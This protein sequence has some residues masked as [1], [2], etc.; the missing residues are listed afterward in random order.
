[1]SLRTSRARRLEALP[2]IV[3]E[4]IVRAA[5]AED[6]GLGGDI[7]S[8]ATVPSGTRATA[9]LVARREGVLAGLDPALLAFR[10]LDPGVR[11]EVLARDGED[12]AQNQTIATLSGD[13]RALLGAERT[14]LNLL[15]HMSGIATATAAYVA[16]VGDERC[17]ICETRKTLPGL[18]AL[19]KYAVRAGGGANH[20]FRLDDAVLIKD[21]HIVAAGGIEAALSRA[22]ERVG[23]LVKIEIEVDGLA[24][25]DDV[26]R[27]ASDV[28]AVL[29]DNFSL[30]D[31]ETAVREIGG[32][33]LIEASGGITLDTVAAV[34]LAGVDVIS[35]GALTH[36][37]TALDIGLDFALTS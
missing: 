14:A 12:L 7:T 3:Y 11:I 9:L 21:N 10:L 27:V 5:L 6:F 25:L 29:L 18:R 37:V 2:Q 19:E 35:I 20:R 16:A 22:R 24:Q 32:R 26:L 33:L 1:M 31:L 23:H 17:A 36:S 30:A 28:D 34:A 13:A 4:P 15:S 8:E